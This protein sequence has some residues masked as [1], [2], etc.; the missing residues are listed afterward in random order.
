VSV[1]DKRD[2]LSPTWVKLKEH[3]AARL[4]D[5]RGANDRSL[6]M[7]D[8]ARLRGRIAEAKYFLELEQDV[9]SD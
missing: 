4:T 8:T 5:L 6:Q 1:L 2:L 7:E 3:F 9:G